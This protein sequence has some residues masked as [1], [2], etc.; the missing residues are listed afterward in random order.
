MNVLNN[1]KTN[2]AEKG[3]TIIEVV[4][5]LAIAGLIF[6]MVFIALPA[7]Q[8][9]QRD[10]ARKNDA[11]A[12]AAAITSYTGNNRG[13]FPSTADLTGS[14]DGSP[15]GSTDKFAGY[16]A[17]VSNNTINVKVQAANSRKAT[18]KQGEIIV[19]KGTKCDSTGAASTTGDDKTA[20]NE[21]A[22]GTSRQFTVVTYLEAGNGSSYCQDS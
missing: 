7:L 18:V 8:A 20:T 22:L 14:S 21:L 13:V 17:S 4:L 9:S 15:D 5:V 2:K 19:T 12:V 11:S 10:G 16:I 1:Y 3:F 6:L